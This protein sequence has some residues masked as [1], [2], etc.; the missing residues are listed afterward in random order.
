MP[1]H[2]GFISSDFG[3]HPVSQLIRGLLQAIDKKR[4]EASTKKGSLNIIVFPTTPLTHECVLPSQCLNRDRVGK[5]LSHHRHFHDPLSRLLSPSCKY[6]QLFVYSLNPQE[7]WWRD[8]I[9]ASVEHMVSLYA[10]TP[11]AAADKIAAVNEMQNCAL[12]SLGPGLIFWSLIMSPCCLSG[13]LLAS[14]I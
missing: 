13:Y 1:D 5:T 4:F 3:I 7:S 12:M 2:P 6:A 9:T 8:N 11:P 14:R 10:L